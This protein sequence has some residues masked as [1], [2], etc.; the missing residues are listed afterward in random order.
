MPSAIE[1]MLLGQMRDAKLPPPAREVVLVPPRQL[2]ADFMW[3]A[4][5]AMPGTD[6]WNM[7]LVVEVDGGGMRGRHGREPGA[8]TDC[9][10]A[11]LCF[12][13]GWD[14]FRFTSKMVR[15]GR[16]IEILKGYFVNTIPRFLLQKPM[17]RKPLLPPRKMKRKAKR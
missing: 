7:V 15:D 11:A 3:A 12:F 2:R 5:A 8:S 10:K 17:E 14:F 1:E 9:E 16:A 6:R 13:K 4:R